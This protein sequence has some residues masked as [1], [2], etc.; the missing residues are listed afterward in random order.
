M[1]KVPFQRYS[2]AAAIAALAFIPFASLATESKPAAPDR[3]ELLSWMARS[4]GVTSLFEAARENDLETLQ[5][6]LADGHAVNAVNE[7]GQTPLHIAA[8]AGHADIALALL[9]AGADTMALDREGLRPSELTADVLIRTACAKGEASRLREL[10]AYAAAEAGDATALSRGLREGV[11]PN[12]AGPENRGNLLSAAISAGSVKCAKMLLKAGA[13]PNG[14]L[15]DGKTMLHIAAGRGNKEITLALLQAGADPLAEAG[16]GASPLHDAV[17]NGR[18]QTIIAMLPYYK[19]VDYCPLGRGLGDPV[20]MAMWRG[21]TDVLKAFLE[22]GLNP[23]LAKF[24]KSPLLVLA[25]KLKNAEMVR[26]LLKA[27][28]DKN[29][30]DQDGKCAADY[31]EGALLELLK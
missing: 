2:M 10:A 3:A 24:K 6:C 27:G 26:L 29:A 19:A 9:S 31:A 14:T 17:W 13:Q 18:V 12:A 22:G 16:N 20:T 5:R 15:Q 25:V 30:K 21:N 4:N 1:N 11:S 7:S 28:A 8:A 23:N